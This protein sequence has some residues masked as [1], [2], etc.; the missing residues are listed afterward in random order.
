ME[1]ACSEVTSD[2]ATVHSYYLTGP[3]LGPRGLDMNMTYSSVLS[4]LVVN[5]TVSECLR[6][7]VYTLYFAWF[8]GSHPISLNTLGIKHIFCKTIFTILK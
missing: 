2:I 7:R 4:S 6:D 3:M 1:F 8:C 5:V